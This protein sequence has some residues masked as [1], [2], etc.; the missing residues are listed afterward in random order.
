MSGLAIDARS[1]DALRAQARQDPKAALGAAATQ[2]EALFAKALLKSLR[3]AAPQHDPLASDAT[4]MA[5]SLLD[6]QLAQKIAERGLG[7]AKVLLGQLA[8]PTPAPG[9]AA[10][11]VQ[12]M[13]P[14]ANAAA[15]QTGVPAKFILAQAALESGWG[16]REVRA[17]GGAPSYNLFGVKAGPRWRGAAVEASTVE[18]AGGVASRRAERFRAYASY[19]EAF[20][21]YARLLKGN[22]RYAGVLAAARD[23]QA[24]AAGL[25]Q[26]GYATDPRYA[27]KLARVID[28][29]PLRGVRT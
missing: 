1:L 12:S 23:A 25:Q 5:Q 8:R 29:A 15:A 26:A 7:L 2:F 13:L 17:P 22:P 10:G 16:A 21:D 9:G 6:E 18:Y 14:H 24:F 19:A 28:S 4:R 11:F 20:A 3:E 27:D